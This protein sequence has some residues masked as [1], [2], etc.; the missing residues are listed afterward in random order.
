MWREGKA[1][2]LKSAW[3]YMLGISSECK[4][5]R[6]RHVVIAQGANVETQAEIR[7][8]MVASSSFSVKI[9]KKSSSVKVDVTSLIGLCL[10]LNR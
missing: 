4:H 6:S 3:S 1:S 8:T 7:N 10:V 9:V 5:G 2:G